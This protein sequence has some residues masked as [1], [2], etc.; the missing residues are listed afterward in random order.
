MAKK[1]SA[2]RR[3]LFI[4]GGLIVLLVILGVVGSAA[5]WFGGERAYAVETATAVVRPVTQ[6]VT[7]S[8]RVQPETEVKISPD[9]SGEI[10]LGAPRP[11]QPTI[12]QA[13][14][15]KPRILLL[16]EPLAALDRKLREEVQVELR[17][18]QRNLGITTVL[19]THDQEEA[20]D[21]ADRVVILDEGKIVQQGT[22]EQVTRNPNSSFV[23]QFL[24]DTLD[25][26]VCHMAL[27]RDPD[28]NDLMLHH[29]YAPPRE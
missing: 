14:I 6:T 7:A 27:F 19:V 25:T 11:G 29:R 3:I 26:G 4:I 10:I 28:G 16:D 12:A 20:L 5:G 1:S 22:P 24:G 8:G 9:V 2:T 18:L 21:L 13:M 23:V 17:E 15:M